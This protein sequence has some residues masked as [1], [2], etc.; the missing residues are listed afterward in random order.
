[1]IVTS[2]HELSETSEEESECSFDPNSLSSSAPQITNSPKLHNLIHLKSL[3]PSKSFPSTPSSLSIHESEL[4]PLLCDNVTYSAKYSQTSTPSHSNN[5]NNNNN[6]GSSSNYLTIS[7][8]NIKSENESDLL[9]DN[10][11]ILY[12]PADLGSLKIFI[13]FQQI[14]LQFILFQ[15]TSFFRLCY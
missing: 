12:S 4:K 11:E 1:V 14:T 5:N 7:G 13:D 3:H 6:S 10:G 8:S 15:N 2:S 9:L